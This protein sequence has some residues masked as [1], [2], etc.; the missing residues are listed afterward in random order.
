MSECESTGNAPAL[1]VIHIEKNVVVVGGGI[2]GIC[3]AV[4]AARLGMRTA[5]I[6][7]RPVLGG[8]ASSEI[9]ITPCGADSPPWNRWARETGLMEEIT[10][11]LAEKA[12]RSDH[13]RWLHYDEL[14]FDTV[15]G[16]PNLEVFLNASVHTVCCLPA[17]HIASVTALQL[18]SE[19]QITVSGAMFIDC[20]GDGTLGF[21]AGAEYR[22]GREAK[23]AFN[24]HYAPDI[25]DAGTMGATLMFSTADRGR[26]MP[27]TAPEWAL[28]VRDLPTILYPGCAWGREFYRMPD[29]TFY[30]LWWAEYGGALDSIHDDDQVVWHTRRLVYGLWD[31]IKNSGKFDNVA[32]LEIDWVGYLPGKRESR[33]LIGDLIATA[34][35]FLDQHSFEDA[36]GHAGWPIDIH[37]P[38]GY[39]DPL[40][41]C[42]HEYLPGITDIPFR[43][44]YSR[45]IDNLLF[46][47]R[48]VSVSHEGL[49]TVRVIATTAVMGQAAGT[50]AALCV[51]DGLSPRTLRE[52]HID[53]LQRALARADQSIIGYQ[54]FE[55]DDL[56]RTAMVTASTCRPAEIAHGEWWHTLTTDVGLIVPV[57]GSRLDMV[58]FYLKSDEL[59][60]VRVEVYRA[61]K[62]QNY[63]FHQLAGTAVVPCEGEGWR[64][65]AV[66]ADVGPGAK[67]LLVI[68]QAENVL[69]RYTRESM[70]GVMGMRPRPDVT[71]YRHDQKEQEAAGAIGPETWFDDLG[72]LPCF[73]LTPEQHWF[74]PTG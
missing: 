56:S 9:R 29:G 30:G 24:E 37:P 57:E 22:M 4:A 5:L 35:D 69:L 15:A 51:R 19:K 27:F 52:D 64:E 41:A 28:D 36:I 26:P 14:Y 31:Y 42:T 2:A 54:L 73:R 39:A 10:L 58:S 59:R 71:W 67:A 68:R 13:W 62:P 63:R 53:T 33:R 66:H 46:A 32:N 61:D 55:E 7:D 72:Y 43:S 23:S 34:N 74:T 40:P 60:D 6:T 20:S 45:N 50:A 70:T 17:G 44:L 11:R 1:R 48:D 49:G 38:H 47:G 21:L 18:R 16:E 3:A 65:F 12:G 25:A 8:S